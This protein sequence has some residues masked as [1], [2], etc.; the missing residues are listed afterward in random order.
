MSSP[1]VE[2][3]AVLTL[4]WLREG[5]ASGRLTP[6]AVLAAVLD[7]IDRHDQPQAW[8]SRLPRQEVLAQARRVAIKGPQGLPLYGVPFAI[9]DNIDLAGVPT[10]AACPAF[11][12]TP[13][14]SA[15]VVERLLAAGAIVVGKTNLDQFATGLVGTRT[16]FGACHSVFSPQHVSGGS[17]SGS[18][19]AVAA[20]LVSFA[21]GTDTAGSG[22]IPAAFNNVVGYKPS[23]GL[24]ST[25]GLVP[26]CRSLDCISVFSL[27]AADSDAVRRVVSAF[28][29]EDPYSR[30]LPAAPP[31]PAAVRLAIPRA[32][33][34]QWF[35]DDAMAEAWLHYLQVL[36]RQGV[37]LV[38]ID[39]SPLREAA[40]LLYDGPWLAER[41]AAVG[42][43]IEQH[44]EAVLPLTRGLIAEGRRPL[45]VDAF[46]AEYRRLSL[47]RQVEQQLAAVTA[48]LLPGAGRHFRLAEIDQ[49][50]LRHN[51]A[52]GTY[53]NFM[54]LLDMAAVAVPG[55]F[56]DD[57]LPF[58]ITVCAAAGTDAL[59]LQLASRLHGWAACGMGVAR[60]SAP[61]PLPLAAAPAEAMVDVAVCGAHL[62]GL[63]LNHQLLDRGALLVQTTRTA[64]DYQLF[65][66]PDTTPPKPG[67]VRTPGFAGPG[68]DIE[69]WRLPAR[70]FGSFVA[71]I[72]APLGI[73]RIRL[74]DGSE[75]MSFLCE[76]HAVQNAADIT[77]FGGWR[78]WL[79]AS[80]A[81]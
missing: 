75:V 57:G 34:L 53:T 4:D 2:L 30:E 8:I 24:L 59:L 28:D 7:R 70:L 16:P 23:R 74:A 19:V 72:P 58:G 45:A 35:D 18:A 3:P 51:S 69:V 42:D 46:R 64:S 65:A 20:G 49:E 41:Y 33:Q 38:E 43:F 31:L 81:R 80:S 54:N 21:L 56:R 32:D 6:E 12:R 26:A 14:R 15:H 68:V 27:T 63:P 55:G 37:T 50:P 60:T 78:A 13:E 5:Y 79:A 29:A 61:P 11:A 9:K 76:A 66:L 39:F 22:R 73:G 67:L 71:G 36:R 25:R 40:R 52:L 77:S 1:R 44:P 48:L 47:K 10:T 62:S 17:S